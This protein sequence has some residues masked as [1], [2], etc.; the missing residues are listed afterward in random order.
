MPS[1]VAETYVASGDPDRL[2]TEIDWIR[3]AEQRGAVVEGRVHHVRSYVVP[4]DEM[5]FHIFEAERASD[6]TRLLAAAGIEVERV[7]ES[8]GLGPGSD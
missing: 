7:V 3:A 2:A 1:F 4:S 6:V 5:G 8:I